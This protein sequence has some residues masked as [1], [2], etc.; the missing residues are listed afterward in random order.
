MECPRTNQYYNVVTSQC[1]NCHSEC[2]S[3]TGPSN[4][5]CSKCP[6]GKLLY[7]G[8][9]L[10][11]CPF[12]W[13]TEN[14]LDCVECSDTNCDDCSKSN[15][16]VCLDCAVGYAPIN[17]VCSTECP[18]GRVLVHNES[19]CSKCPR[20]CRTCTLD[21]ALEY[22]DENMKCTACSSSNDI[23]HEGRC[24]NTC[25]EGSQKVKSGSNYICQAISCSSL[26]ENCLSTQKCLECKTADPSDP[27]TGV[28]QTYDN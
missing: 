14:G 9:C 2:D 24:Q 5:E 3:C 16:L 21:I 7:N 4:F 8:N 17:G 26:C 19:T 28:I 6:N 11:Q 22:N 13:A 27:F 18:E 23:L 15:P 10:N 20:E 12:G 25:P 1:N